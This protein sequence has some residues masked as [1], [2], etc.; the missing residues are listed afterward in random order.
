MPFPQL[1]VLRWFMVQLL[2]HNFSKVQEFKLFRLCQGHLPCPGA[3]LK[4]H[5]LITTSNSIVNKPSLTNFRILLL[6]LGR[7][8]GSD[9]M[10]WFAITRLVDSCHQNQEAFPV[11]FQMCS[12]VNC[13]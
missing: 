4:T 12:K 6:S 2:E 11:F 5:L 10:S 1:D 8:G 9:H 7:V 13:Y 3:S